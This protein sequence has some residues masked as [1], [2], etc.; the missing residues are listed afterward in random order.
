MEGGS[1]GGG[2]CCYGEGE[3]IVAFFFFSFL[4]FLFFSFSFSR[5]WV[6]SNNE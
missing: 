6:G 4:F 5:G 1:Y 2:R 3:E